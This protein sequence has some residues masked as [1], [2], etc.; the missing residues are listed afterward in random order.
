M[1]IYTIILILLFFA[2]LA[3]KPTYF[4][5][6]EVTN[7]EQEIGTAFGC[8]GLIIVLFLKAHFPDRVFILTGREY[9]EV[10]EE[11]SNS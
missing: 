8:S 10:L 11:I 4:M 1:S 7:K 2:V 3:A 5:M 6:T 9:D